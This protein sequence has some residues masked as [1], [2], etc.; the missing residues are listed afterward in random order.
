MCVRVKEEG[1]RQNEEGKIV[2][3]E[4]GGGPPHSRMLAQIA[5]PPKRCQGR[6]QSVPHGCIEDE[7]EDDWSYVQR[8][9][10]RGGIMK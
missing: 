1:R 2:R 6:R 9:C 8:K 4:S 7:D 5:Q 3:R 10:K